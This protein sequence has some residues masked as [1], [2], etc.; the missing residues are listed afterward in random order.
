MDPFYEVLSG[1]RML[2]MCKI[3]LMLLED[4]NVEE[5]QGA[6][7]EITFSPKRRYRWRLLSAVCG[8]SEGRKCSLQTPTPSFVVYSVQCIFEP[9]LSDFLLDLQQPV[10]CKCSMA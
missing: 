9:M 6:W 1:E 7:L 3:E 8:F 4:Q 5:L 10:V 2:E